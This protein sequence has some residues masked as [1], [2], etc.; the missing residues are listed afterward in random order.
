LY[1]IVDVEQVNWFTFASMDGKEHTI[2]I[3]GLSGALGKVVGGRLLNEGHRLLAIV[4]N[5][6]SENRTK[7]DF[8][9]MG[10]RISFFRA[11]LTTDTFE[12]LSTEDLSGF[13]HLA[14]GFDA[15]P[16]FAEAPADQLEKQFLLNTRSAFQLLRLVLP[17]LKKRGGGSIVTISA[18]AALQPDGSNA[19]YAAS[20][21]ALLN[22]TL[23]AAREGRKE[24]VRANV[25]VPG[26]IDTP[27][28]RSWGSADQIAKWTTPEDIASCICW[29]MSDASAGVNGTVIPMYGQL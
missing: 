25:I 21:A 9:G 22:L 27:A 2:L 7:A 20:K 8:P 1:F 24:N 14:G 10:N 13:V 19:A 28:N 16:T 12:G 23:Q 15:A 29:L 11:D 17:A 6:S 3:T 4:R 26:V 18:K 5:E